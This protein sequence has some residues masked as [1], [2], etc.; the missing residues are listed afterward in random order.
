M[1]TIHQINFWTF[2]INLI[3]FL[4]PFLGMLFMMVLGFVQ[5]IL[6]LA[7]VFCHY[8]RLDR[9]IRIMIIGYWIFV[10][11][12]FIG[13]GATHFYSNFANDA[14]VIPFLFLIPGVLAIYFVYTTYTITKNLSHEYPAPQY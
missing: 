12:D 7:I 8:R 3:L 10:V 6:A 4:I 1:K 14:L 11:I 5:I 2:I 13:I 9:N